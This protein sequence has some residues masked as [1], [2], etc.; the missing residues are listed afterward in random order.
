MKREYWI[1]KLYYSKIWK[2]YIS[3]E[4]EEVY[5]N[6]KE[7]LQEYNR[8]KMN[9]KDDEAVEFWLVDWDDVNDEM[10]DYK[11]KFRFEKRRDK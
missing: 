11:V 5:D 8:T 4:C 3:Y 6:Y 1:D 10:I 9:L 7:A 2:T